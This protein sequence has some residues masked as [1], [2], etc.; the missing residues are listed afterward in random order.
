MQFW[1][2]VN[3]V[4]VDGISSTIIP[5]RYQLNISSMSINGLEYPAHTQ[6]LFGM[7]SKLKIEDNDSNK[8]HH[9]SIPKELI[10]SDLFRDTIR[11]VMTKLYQLGSITTE[12]IQ[13]FKPM[14][15]GVNEKIKLSR[16]EKVIAKSLGYLEEVCRS[17][18][19]HLNVEIERV[20]TERARRIPP[21]AIEYLASHDE[22]WSRR[23][24]NGIEPEKI[25]SEIITDDFNIY[26]NRLAATLIDRLFEYLYRRINDFNAFKGLIDSEKQIEKH[27]IN[28]WHRSR[29][30]S[31]WGDFVNENANELAESTLSFLRSLI[32]RVG[33]LKDSDLYKNIPPRQRNEGNVMDTNIIANE[34]NYREVALLLSTMLKLDTSG[35]KKSEHEVYN[36]Q[37]HEVEAYTQYCHLLTL[38]ALIEIGFE[39]GQKENHSDKRSTFLRSSHLPNIYIQVNDDGCMAIKNGSGLNILVVPLFASLNGSQNFQQ[40]VIKNTEDIKSPHPGATRTL[41]LY[42]D[43]A[44]MSLDPNQ[45]MQGLKLG[46]HAYENDPTHTK[47]LCHVSPFSFYNVERIGL[48]LRKWIYGSVYSDYPR[49]I[50]VRG[51]IRKIIMEKI[52]W[53]LDGN[54]NR[55]LRLINPVSTSDIMGLNRF[56][57]AEV[58]RAAG[59]GRDFISEKKDLEQLKEQ[60]PSIQEKY[61]DVLNCPLCHSTANSASF[62]VTGDNTFQC[63]CIACGAKWG[64]YACSSCGDTF[65]FIEPGVDS[66]VAIEDI[67]MEPEMYIGLDAI[68]IPCSCTG[69]GSLNL[70]CSKCGHCSKHGVNH[71][72]EAS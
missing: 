13:S 47:Y 16:F 65:P 11:E 55:T 63:K 67:Y 29:V 48:N 43:N 68:S 40:G 18:I 28:H 9:F 5:D 33:R 1:D 51:S 36:D 4:E 71:F 2:K 45:F 38:R 17:P 60:T 8:T 57:D 10:P 70:T 19:T 39:V 58:K 53:L 30:Y 44:Q 41:I 66:P 59:K 35:I 12:D 25:L 21:N 61:A 27:S 22:D 34:Q 64:L 50:P 54:D 49:T 56:L 15:H 42:P 24:I 52:P 37:L 72:Q 62:L 32:S 23:T 31:V 26:E 46:I 6:L 20:Q 14:V 7:T 3:Q 69:D